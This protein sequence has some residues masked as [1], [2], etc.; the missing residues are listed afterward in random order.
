MK[1]IGIVS[2]YFNP[3][4]YGHVVYINE[5]KKQC[6]FLTAI[7]NS[8]YQVK[9][10][11]SKEFMDEVHRQRIVGNLRSVDDTVICI[12]QDRTVCKTIELVKSWYPHFYVR[13]F[14]SGDRGG[15]N[16]ETEEI[17]ICNTIGV[18]YVFIEQP[19]IYASSELLKP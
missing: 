7:I 2:G 9:L 11:G 14:N 1:T 13:F 5:A 16:A 12:D 3:L 4:H 15:L 19:K 17:L 8:D 10:K 18:E 6:D